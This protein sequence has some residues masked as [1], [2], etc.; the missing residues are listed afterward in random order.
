MSD[1]ETNKRTVKVNSSGASSNLELHTWKDYYLIIRERVFLGTGVAVLV[2]GI[3]TYVLM[4]QDPVYASEGAIM[5]DGPSER[6]LDMEEVVEMGLDRSGQMW[7]VSVENHINQLRSRTFRDYVRESF[8]D[9]EEE[10]I[11]NAYRKDDVQPSVG[12]ILREVEIEE[13]PD[14]FV[15]TVRANHRESE[16]AAFI[17]NRYME[18]YLAFNQ[19]RSQSGN[20]S[21]IRFLTDQERDLR[22]KLDQAEEE[23]QNFRQ[24]HNLVTIDENR[25][26][27]AQRLED[28]NTN[29]TE[30]RMNRIQLESRV[31]QVERY[32]SEGKNLLE[33]FSLSSLGSTPE[34]LSELD[35][36]R[37]DRE[38]MSERYGERHPAMV[39]HQRA[40]TAAKRVI[41]S[42]IELAIA[43]L[44]GQLSQARE[45]EDDLLVEL[46]EAEQRSL[47]LDR[48]KMRFQA[49][50]RAVTAT[51]NTHTQVMDR[52]DETFITSQMESSTLEILDAAGASSTP[53]H[54]NVTRISML[55]VFLGFFLFFGTPIGLAAIDNKLK[56]A[57]DVEEYL[58]H[59]LLGE[60]SSVSH[61]KRATR[62]HVVVEGSDDRVSE[63]FRG[64]FSQIEITS[65]KPYPKVLMT[66]ST[67]PGEGKSFV[68]NNLASCFAAHGKRTLMVDFDLR[69]PTLHRFYSRLNSVGVMSWL[70]NEECQTREPSMEELGI[71]EV[72]PGLFLLSS[73]GQTTRATEV[74]GNPAVKKLLQCLKKKFD[75][76]LLDTP[77]VGVFSDALPLSREAD[78]TVFVVH[79]GKVDRQQVRNTLRRLEEAN[80]DVIG[81]VMNNM[82]KG[83][84]FSHYYSGYG[85]ESRQYAKYYTQK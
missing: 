17:A 71:G 60:V 12:R 11:L 34:V 54:P 37:K 6:I 29:L 31:R 15:V 39:G 62:P 83:S 46:E 77:P 26:A 25:D 23:M 32:Q 78:E 79:F 68:L 85:F 69:R 21:A 27:I 8:T 13:V 55:V 9:E 40:I 48:I 47:E 16:P 75:I 70:D 73:G 4:S 72:G 36:L 74:I 20:E 64:A 2:A 44:W 56:H 61:L 63:A 59:K 10:E 33:L 18:R 66:T 65:Q 51:R 14:S 41:R 45:H 7:R 43:D 52:L 84:R 19:E 30:A 67:I 57:R 38:V 53:V 24:E 81:V 28:I 1:T 3:I 80:A 50:Q 49:L 82:P 76:L 35:G 42:N 5:L 22:K 58:E